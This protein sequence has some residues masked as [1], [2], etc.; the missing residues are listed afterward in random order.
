MLAVSDTTLKHNVK[1]AVSV[2]FCDYQ[3]RSPFS[4]LVV[5][6]NDPSRFLGLNAADLSQEDTC[7]YAVTRLHPW[8]IVCLRT[9]CTNKKAPLGGLHGC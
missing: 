4:A 7:L 8:P 6:T 3:T 9:N 1:P 5:S 2:C